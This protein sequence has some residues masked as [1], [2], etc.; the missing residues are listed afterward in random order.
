DR[1][2]W[3]RRNAYQEANLQYLSRYHAMG[4]MA[5]ILAHELGQPLAASTNYLSG[6]K[7]RLSSETVDARSLEYGIDQ[8]EKQLHRAAD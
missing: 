1:V 7:A 4:D 2:E 5:M 3:E 8:I 6:L